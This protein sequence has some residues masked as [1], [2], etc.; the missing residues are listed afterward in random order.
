MTARSKTQGFLAPALFGLAALAFLLPF[1]TVSCDGAETTFTGVQ[2]VTKTVPAGGV[3]HDGSVLGEEVEDDATLFAV[4]ALAAA[5]FGFAL[6]AFGV[7]KGPGWV[8]AVGLVSTL[9]MAQ[10]TVDVFGPTITFH[11]GYLL[12]LL[13]FLAASV[14]YAWRAI[15]RRRANNQDGEPEAQPLQEE[16]T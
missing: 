5:V 9:L 12:T 10:S 3:T 14:L 2:L 11:I 8:A 6:S 13:L 1:A 16:A 15:K 4:A 7:V